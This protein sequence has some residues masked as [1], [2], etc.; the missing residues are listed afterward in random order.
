M[1]H[2]RAGVLAGFTLALCGLVGGCQSTPSLSA[3]L[4]IMGQPAAMPRPRATALH[5]RRA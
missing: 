3:I 2:R 1:S 4:R 5:W